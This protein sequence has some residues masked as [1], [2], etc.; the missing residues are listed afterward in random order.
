[1]SAILQ[2]S[3]LAASQLPDR[4]LH[5]AVG[6]FDGLHRGHQA[7]IQQAVDAAKE[8]NGVA[9]VLTFWPH[10]SVLFRPQD[11]TRL[12]MTPA[13]KAHVL[14]RLGVSALITEPFTP[15]FAALPAEK[16]LPML[17]HNLPRLKVVYVGEN[18]RFGRGRMGDVGLLKQ[19]AKGSG[20]NVVSVPRV[21]NEDEAISSTAIR[22]LLEKGEIERAN[23]MLGYEYFADGTVVPGKGLGRKIGFPTLN[24]NWV[25]DLRPRFGV[26]AVKVRKEDGSPSLPG[27]ANYGLRPTVEDTTEPRLE[28]HLLTDC[29]YGPGEEL[30]VEF[31]AFLRGEQQFSGVIEL[32]KQIARDRVTAASIL[33]G[34]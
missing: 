8:E 24:L 21:R 16:F 18:W 3:G 4:P 5:L 11:V 7:V 17:Q 14:N 22:S 9:A 20:L 13:V 23:Q 28:V 6:M 33:A 32:E 29:P 10:P 19:S 1:V 30:T 15:E 31:H 26:Y 2:F 12:I 27:V 25:P 34:A